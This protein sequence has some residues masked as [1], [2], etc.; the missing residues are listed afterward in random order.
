MLNSALS[1]F[2]F[3]HKN[4]Q[5]SFQLKAVEIIITIKKKKK[6]SSIITLIKAGRVEHLESQTLARKS[7]CTNRSELL[8]PAYSRCFCVTLMTTLSVPIS[9]VRLRRPFF[10]LYDSFNCCHLL[11]AR[12]AR[13]TFLLTRVDTDKEVY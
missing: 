2:S 4:Q 1:C 8:R 7:H 12:P 10:K 11:P 5:C 13:H 9:S 3:C 6:N